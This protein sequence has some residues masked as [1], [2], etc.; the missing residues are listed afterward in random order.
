M[1]AGSGCYREEVKLGDPRIPALRI[2]EMA[3]D[4]PSLNPGTGYPAPALLCGW[5]EVLPR[6]GPDS[7]R[8]LQRYGCAEVKGGIVS[9]PF[10]FA[11]SRL[12]L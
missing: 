1:D 5:A 3:M 4:C 10:C 11:D 9:I 7:S 8:P 2:E 6:L 12:R